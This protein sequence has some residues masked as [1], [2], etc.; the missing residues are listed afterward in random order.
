MA[1]TTCGSSARPA[2]S[3]IDAGTAP[4]AVVPTGTRDTLFT[5]NG[6]GDRLVAVGGSGNGRVVALEGAAWRDE[7]PAGAGLLQGVFVTAHGDWASGERG[8]V[9][10]RA[11]GA[12]A[13]T[14]VDHGL[15]L[16][17]S[18]SL[19]S[20]FVDE[21][22]E[23][24]SAGGNVLSPSLDG[25]VLLH[26]GAPIPQVTLEDEAE[27]T[28]TMDAG[29]AGCPAAVVTAGKGKSVA[30]RWDEQALAAIRLDLPA[31]HGPRAQP[32]PSL[33]RDVGRVVR[34]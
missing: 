16:A 12:N 25:G 4:F 34:V 19:H 31:P 8:A 17:P 28:A 9:Y 22:G 23:V 27:P 24:W 15:T 21:K 10:H 2:R 30:R 26:Y 29:A 18:T 11:E 1:A 7:S 13:F 6:A 32:V 20:V 5:V 3:C 33:R 14:Y